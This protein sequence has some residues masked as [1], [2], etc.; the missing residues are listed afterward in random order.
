MPFT[1]FHMGPAALLK[2]ALAQ[3]FS[4]MVFGVSQVLIDIE[5][6]VRIIRNDAI[7]HG[8]THTVV[9]ALAIAP[10][11][12]VIGRTAGNPV[13][14]LLRSD[15]DSGFTQWSIGPRITWAVAGVSAFIG[16]LSHVALDSIMHE[17][18][19]PLWPFAG[20][21]PLLA[22]VSI[23]ALHVFCLVAGLVG[24]SVYGLR[25]LMSAP[26]SRPTPPAA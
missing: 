15:P 16:T 1:P 2:A 5:P 4:I 17:D 3:R 14:D 24:G 18:M 25:A 10:V 6:L 21:N 22:F 26:P 9:G 23:S 8:P 20:P 11:A 12:A 7:L 19:H 13:L